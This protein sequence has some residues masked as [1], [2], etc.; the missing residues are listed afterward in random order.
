MASRVTIDQVGLR[1]LFSDETG[2]IAAAVEGAAVRAQETMERLLS[3]P[4][5]G[6]EYLTHRTVEIA[7]AP[8][9]P[10]AP[11]TGRLQGSVRVQMRTGA[12]GIYALVGSDVPEAHLTE[13]GTVHMAPRP[14]VRPTIASIGGRTFGV[15][16][17]L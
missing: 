13:F 10:P 7:S 16:E 15:V 6:R 11:F 14:F 4:G 8:G 2:P 3:Q 12:S 5:A 17:R 9:Q 1:E